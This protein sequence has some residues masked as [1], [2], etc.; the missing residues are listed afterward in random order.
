MILRL[1]RVAGPSRPILVAGVATHIVDAAL[2]VLPIGLLYLLLVKALDGTWRE[3]DTIWLVAALVAT[4][5][6]QGLAHYFGSRACYHAGFRLL[7][8]LR[9]RLADHMARLPLG[10]FSERA[11]GDLASVPTRDITTVEPAPTHFLGEATAS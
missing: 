10:F 3:A 6:G 8:D 1:L 9:M 4:L 5:V 11:V 7:A 2:A